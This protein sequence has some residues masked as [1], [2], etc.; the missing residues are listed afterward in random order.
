MRGSLG[1]TQTRRSQYCQEIQEHTSCCSGIS[2]EDLMSKAPDN[3]AYTE[4]VDTRSEPADACSNCLS[5]QC[6]PLAYMREP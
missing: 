6:S 1:K 5:P 4:E 2:A 3:C